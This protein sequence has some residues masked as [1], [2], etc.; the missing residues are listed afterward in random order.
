MGRTVAVSRMVLAL[1]NF[2]VLALGGCEAY[3]P[4]SVGGDDPRFDPV[5]AAVESEMARLGVSGAAVAIVE[6]GEVTFAKGF[7]TKQDEDDSP[8]MTATLF[9]I[10]SITKMM[11]AVGLLQQVESGAAAL[12][13][14][15]T[16]HL[17]SLSFALDDTWAPSIAL[18]DLLTHSS[19]IVNYLET[20]ADPAYKSETG[21][22]E[23]LLEAFPTWGYLMVP[24]GT[25]YNY[26]NIGYSYVG[27]VVET[28]GGKYYR[29][30]MGEN[31]F[32]PLGMFR[33]YFAPE[34]VIADDNY[35]LG[36]STDVGGG[37]DIVGPSSYENPWG[38]PAGFAWSSVLDLGKF[39]KFLRSGNSAVLSDALRNEMMSPKVNM[40]TLLDYQY[41]AYGLAISEGI[42]VGDDWYDMR[43][44][45]HSGGIPGYTAHLYYIPELDFGF[46]ALAN[47]NNAPLSGVLPTA[48]STLCELPTP[49]EAPGLETTDEMLDSL[50]G[51]Y[52]D[53]Y[54]LGDVYIDRSG[55][56]IT[57]EI[58]L[59]DLYGIAYESTALPVSPY[60]FVFLSEEGSTN[61]TFMFENDE[62]P[63]PRWIRTREMVAERIDD[64][65]DSDP[66]DDVVDDSTI[67]ET[68][69]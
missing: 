39:L 35:A 13:D 64:I 58:P 49:A 66:I 22:S 4:D 11:T 1:W 7:G 18:D 47:R 32:G 16:D 30:Y 50:I 48:L 68:T 14:P 69:F 51:H 29:T 67:E 54:R 43:V 25:F 61:V 65:N 19:G 52:V 10:G 60:N 53:P 26:S 45:S 24:A 6:E 59:Y 44:I 17:P 63:H 38:D 3:D 41:Y 8:V 12:S 42:F 33:T 21:L 34:Q 20:D 9:R 55:D 31:V 57:V 23:F 15:V 27:L 46:I 37:V 56:D 40:K 2:G 5:M 62:D 28:L 36:T